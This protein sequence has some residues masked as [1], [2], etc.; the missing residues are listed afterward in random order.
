MEGKQL[1]EDYKICH[2]F[3][4]WIEHEYAPKIKKR[5]KPNFEK[6]PY[7]KE[8]VE[9]SI[10]RMLK[11]DDVEKKLKPIEKSNITDL[12]PIYI[13]DEISKSYN[14]KNNF[15]INQIINNFP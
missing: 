10:E 9:A 1:E 3:G 14:S 13:N 5:K 4:Y 12:I 7:S 6:L 8:V 2:D 11:N 15:D